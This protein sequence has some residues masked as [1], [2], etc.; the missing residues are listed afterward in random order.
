MNLNSKPGDVWD[1]YIGWYNPRNNDYTAALKAENKKLKIALKS[2]ISATNN[3]TNI[4]AK[5]YSEITW[6]RLGACKLVEEK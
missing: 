3:F 5:E 6:A 2:L 1:E 4:G